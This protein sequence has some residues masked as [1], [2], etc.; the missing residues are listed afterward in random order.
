MDNMKIPFY[1]R[2]TLIFIGLIAFISIL[3]VAQDIIVP[4]MYATIIAILLSPLVDLLVKRK[5][6]R[7][8]AIAITLIGVIAIII[9]FSMLLSHE[10]SVF[11]DTF[12]RLLDKFSET[13]QHAAKWVSIH[14]HIS[15][16]KINSY[17][18]DSRTALLNGSR[19]SI[20]VT[21]SSIGNVLVV[22]L[23]IPVYVFMILFYQPLL[24]DFIRRLFGKTNNT[25]VNEVLVATR[26]II[27][28]YLAALFVEAG[29]VATLNSAGLMIIGIDYAILLGILGALLNMIPYIGGVI[30]VLLPMAV[31]YVT[32][33]TPSYALM[34]MLVYMT[35]QFVDNHYIFPK[36]V[37]SK[38]RI[39]ALI[40]LIVVLCGGALWGISGMFL[41]IPIIAILKVIFDHIDSMKP[42]G[43]LLGDT[44]PPIAIFKIKL[45]KKL[46]TVK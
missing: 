25:E 40:S 32:K 45:K 1:A 34:V 14:F 18:A 38:V 10:L 6:N 22:L 7:V 20:G 8:L 9:I 46:M 2:A 37:S 42:W 13:L 23:L 36:I 4:I 35:I 19:S 12:P 33:S 27:R 31:A 17:I 15:A 30:A 16:T 28:R 24:L 29:I 5:M 21:L 41:S 11:T 43:F 39:N 44:M 3:Y 26:T